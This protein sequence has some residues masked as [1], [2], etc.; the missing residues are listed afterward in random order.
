MNAMFEDLKVPRLSFTKIIVG[1][2]ERVFAFYRDVFGIEQQVR[3][4]IGEGY[5]QL[6][7]IVSKAVGGVGAPTLVIKSFVNRP[8]PAPGEMQIG[9]VVPNVD[10]TI[11]AALAAGGK[12]LK[13]A[14]DRPEHGIRVAFLHDVEG[15]TVEIVEML[16]AAKSV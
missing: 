16:P 3:V 12:V 9:F 10:A 5:D 4:K 15:H 14:V 11:S 7:E 1:D 2:V 13:P 6:D 8:A